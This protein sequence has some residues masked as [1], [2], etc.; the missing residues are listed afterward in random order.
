MPA[1]TAYLIM[2][3]G[4][5]IPKTK[6][7]NIV[8]PGCTLVVEVHSGEV[9]YISDFNNI[10]NYTNKSI[11]LDPINN[12]KEL[13]G[14]IS[15]TQG[16]LA[17]YKEGDEYPDFQYNLLSYWNS[18]ALKIVNPNQLMLSDSGIMEYPFES[19]QPNHIIPNKNIYDINS[20]SFDIF[21]DKFRNS[22]YPSKEV[23]KKFINDYNLSTFGDII[24][25]FNNISKTNQA[26][27]HTLLDKYQMNKAKVMNS[28]EFDKIVNPEVYPPFNIK[29][30]LNVKQSQLFKKLPHGVFYNLIC[31][32]TSDKIREIA[33]VFYPFSYHFKIHYSCILSFA[34]N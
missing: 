27:V 1:Q 29:S 25:T 2:G 28:N 34:I 16:S 20:P 6:I 12:Y 26:K 24:Y 14:A 11:F 9:N 4:S 3:H 5:E 8:P 32:T 18:K 13:V 33:K 31:R 21:P 23:V 30:I 17:I 15:N 10:I 7:R 19:I 22:I